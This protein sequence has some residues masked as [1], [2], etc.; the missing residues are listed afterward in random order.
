METMQPAPVDTSPSPPSSLGLFGTK[1]PA[2]AAFLL[3]ILLF[4]LPFAEV[5]CN[6]TALANNTG[7]GIAMG[8]QWK[9]VVSKNIF[10]ESVNTSNDKKEFN[11]Q[12][13]PNL[14]AI[15]ALA[16]GVL[17]LIIAFL[18]FKGGEKINLFMGL[19]AAILLIAMLID[20]K[21]KAKSDTSVKSTDLNFNMGMK[22]TV[23]GTPWFYLTLILFLAAAFFS[24][25]RSK[26][27]V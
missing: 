21:S 16:F 26:M 7:L 14:F 6:D 27:K 25:Q 11:Q 22:V 20:L 1:I 2:T 8:T 18:N 10:G 4:L 19:L 12:Q 5:K 17:G 9:E 3:G 13:D 15:S 24:W 23:D